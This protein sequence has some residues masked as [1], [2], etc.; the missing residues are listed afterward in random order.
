MQSLASDAFHYSLIKRYTLYH[1]VPLPRIFKKNLPPLQLYPTIRTVRVECWV[2]E[3]YKNSRNFC[4]VQKCTLRVKLKLNVWLSPPTSQ[5]QRVFN[6][7]PSS[8]I[9]GVR[10]TPCWVGVGDF[11]GEGA[12][13]MQTP[14]CGGM[15]SG[16]GGGRRL[17][18]NWKFIFGHS[19]PILTTFQG[20]WTVQMENRGLK[21]W[22]RCTP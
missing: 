11:S 6:P 4:K 13:F 1:I 3:M 8:E 16:V 19:C 21:W 18:R 17:S 12:D 20:I 10:F 2:C 14:I 15:S 22:N 7:H 9:P 5:P